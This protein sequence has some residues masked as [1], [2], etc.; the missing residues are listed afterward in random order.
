MSQYCFWKLVKNRRQN[1]YLQR[2]QYQEEYIK[3]LRSATRELIVCGCVEPWE[4]H[5]TSTDERTYGQM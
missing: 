4:G 2:S 5:M 1:L 3:P